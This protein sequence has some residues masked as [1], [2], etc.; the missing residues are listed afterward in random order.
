MDGGCGEAGHAV[1]GKVLRGL[2]DADSAHVT[3]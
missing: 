1:D 2:G 3:R